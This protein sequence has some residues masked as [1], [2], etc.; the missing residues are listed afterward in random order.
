M[1]FAQTYISTGAARSFYT[2]GDMRGKL[3]QFNVQNTISERFQIESGLR[4]YQYRRT[5]KF[6]YAKNINEPANQYGEL[7]HIVN[8]NE[9][10]ANVNY[11]IIKRKIQLTA[12]VGGGIAFINSTLPREFGIILPVNSGFPEPLYTSFYDDD[13]QTIKPNV[14]ANIKLAY[15]FK[16]KFIVSIGFDFSYPNQVLI[17]SFPISL[18]YKI[19]DSKNKN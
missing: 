19:S 9:P 11:F 13:L 8:V 6:A 12:G 5:Y 3:I 16:S 2:R 18:S 15:N 17:W 4:I 14:N 10:Y 7:R 1:V